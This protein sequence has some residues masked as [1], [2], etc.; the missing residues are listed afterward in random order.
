MDNK[1]T[2]IVAYV[3]FIG[4]I[5]AFAMGN[6]EECKFHLNQGLVL[7][8]VCVLGSAIVGFIPLL[9]SIFYVFEVIFAVLGIISAVNGEENPLPLIGGIKLLK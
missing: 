1:V 5:V 2:N 7:A 6:R 8:I 3:T 9:G 4:W